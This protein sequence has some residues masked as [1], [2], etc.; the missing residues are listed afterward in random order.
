MSGF[1]RARGLVAG[2][3]LAWA[4]QLAAEPATRKV[5][6]NF[7]AMVGAERFACGKSYSGIGVT[8]T[9]ITPSDFGMFVYDVKLVTADGK[10]VPVALDQDGKYQ[11][12]SVALLDFEDGTGACSNGNAELHTAV[13]GTVPEGR[14]VGVTFTIG[15]PFERNHLDLAA[16]PSP[17]SL[18]RMFWAWNSGHKFARFDAKSASGKSWVLHLGSTGCAPTG[19]ATASPAS[20]AQENRVVVTLPKFDA[21]REV[22]IAD[23][24]VLFSGNGNPAADENQVCMSSPKSAACAPMFARLGLPFNGAPGE[25]KFLRVAS[26]AQRAG[27]N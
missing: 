25:Q 23:A 24:A 26:G 27:G 19:V 11:S 18:T 10:Q 7:R 3:A 5:S 9:T 4:S 6:I 21:D 1:S 14:Y 13:T 8:N 22:V 2:V 17:L 16:S 15:V 20:C 12:E